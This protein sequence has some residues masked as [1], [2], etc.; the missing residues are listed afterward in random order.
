MNSSGS[1]SSGKRTLVP[2]PSIIGAMWLSL[3]ML[4]SRES[5][6]TSSGT[7]SAR[8]GPPILKELWRSIGSFSSR[9]IPGSAF[10]TAA[11]AFS[12]FSRQRAEISSALMVSLFSF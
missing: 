5:E 4:H 7:A 3:R 6:L 8:T 11:I 10:L 1:P 9:V 12:R 2:F